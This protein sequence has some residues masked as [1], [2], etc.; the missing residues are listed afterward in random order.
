MVFK[1][2]IVNTFSFTPCT[3][4][5]KSS[6]NGGYYTEWLD[7]C[8]LGVWTWVSLYSKMEYNSANYDYYNSAAYDYLLWFQGMDEE[9]IFQVAG[10]HVTV[11]QYAGDQMFL[12]VPDV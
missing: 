10:W 12:K 7:E 4:Y 3:I 2:S 8:E 9:V 1:K 5:P 11:S 6:T